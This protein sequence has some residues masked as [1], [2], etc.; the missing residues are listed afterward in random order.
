M[1]PDAIREMLREILMLQAN[2]DRAGAS[3]MLEVYG[4]MSPTLERALGRLDGIPVDIR[5]IYA[6]AGKIIQG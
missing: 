2:G 6:S 1:A 3:K 4:A 5:P